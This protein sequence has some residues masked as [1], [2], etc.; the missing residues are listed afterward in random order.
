MKK[1]KNDLSNAQRMLNTG[2]LEDTKTPLRLVQK[3]LTDLAQIYRDI[4]STMDLGKDL[5]S[6]LNTLALRLDNTADQMRDAL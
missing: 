3:D 2:S 4:A 6:E 5:N 1:T